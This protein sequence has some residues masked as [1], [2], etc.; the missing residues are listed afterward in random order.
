MGHLL[1][2]VCSLALQA[3]FQHTRLCL[4][5]LTYLSLLFHTVNH[6]PGTACSLATAA[7]QRAPCLLCRQAA[8]E[9]TKAAAAHIQAEEAI[10]SEV[11]KVQKV[12][13]GSAEGRIKNATERAALA[14]FI[15]ALCPPHHQ[16]LQDVAEHTASFLADFYK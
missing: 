1:P 11:S 4:L 14:A 3:T 12:L 6:M 9:V 10:Q 7:S 16:G 15:A 13:G 2:L 8:L 5:K